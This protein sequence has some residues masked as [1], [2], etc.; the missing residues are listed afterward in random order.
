V[1]SSSRRRLRPPAVFPIVTICRVLEVSPSGFW[2]WS[3]RP[4]SERART[5]AA[6]TGEIRRIHH[7][8]RG[9]SGVARVHAELRCDGTRCSRKRVARL[10]TAAGLA[11][12]HHRR[13]VRTTARDR[14]SA[15]A[16]TLS[17][18]P[19]GRRPRISFGLPTSPTTRPG[20]ASCTSR[21]SSTCSVGWSM[22]GH[23]R[24]EL[25]LDAL[26][27]AIARRRPGDGLV[28]HSDRGTQDTSLA[29]GRR[30]REA[31]I[32]PSM[33]STGDAYDNAMAESFFASLE[34]EL[35]DWT[36]FRTRADARLA[37]FDYME[38][39]LEP[40]SPALRHG[41]SVAGRVREEVPF[42]TDHR[43]MTADHPRNRGNFMPFKQTH[44]RSRRTFDAKV[45]CSSSS[46]CRE[47]CVD[48]EH[49]ARGE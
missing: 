31:G 30:A 11:G 48:H 9:T 26:D 10:M 43:C 41:L 25:I 44:Q 7:R 1:P 20:P 22:A 12:V 49:G 24:T 13:A 14:N 4:T 23:M 16:P 42:R 40:P 35:L 19:S 18:G 6:L 2:A 8:S 29:F 21:S 36:S 37:V 39:F 15:P 33:G 3:K 46:C 27:M 45:R 47:T 34:T 5:D 38:A 17:T 32:A 28:H